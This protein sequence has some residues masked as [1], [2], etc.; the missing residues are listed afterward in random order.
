MKIGIIEGHLVSPSITKIY[1]VF[2]VLSPS[3]NY[4]SNIFPFC[5][6]KISICRRCQVVFLL[7]YQKAV[8]KKGFLKLPSTSNV[9]FFNYGRLSKCSKEGIKPISNSYE[10]KSTHPI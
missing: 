3:T 5:Y 4:F 9:I 6:E 8:Q 7:L 1:L 2:G 10:K